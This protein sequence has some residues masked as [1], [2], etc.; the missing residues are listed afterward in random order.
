MSDGWWW[1]GA[2]TGVLAGA[3]ATLLM[4]QLTRALLDAR[5]ERSAPIG[6]HPVDSVL[7]GAVGHA[8]PGTAADTGLGLLV[9]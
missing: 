7:R 8:V 6:A 4:D 3:G 9:R 1:V 2:V 5:H